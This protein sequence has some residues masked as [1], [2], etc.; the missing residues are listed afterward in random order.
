M[1]A[2]NL[3]GEGEPVPEADMVVHA[4][5]FR[6]DLMVRPGF[7]AHLGSGSVALA[8]SAGLLALRD[9]AADMVVG[10]RFPIQFDHTLDGFSIREV[11][12]EAYRVAK[13]GAALNIGCSSCDLDSLAEAVSDAGFVDVRVNLRRYSVRG[14][15]P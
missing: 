8:T 5:L 4:N 11:G 13:P 7:A 1:I 3:G 6:A 12:A 2:V 10:R 14:R 15:K 9:G